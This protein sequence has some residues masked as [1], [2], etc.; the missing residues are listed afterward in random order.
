MS[1][2]QAT[3]EIEYPESDRKPMGET[4]LHIDWIIRIRDMLKLRYRG[5]QVYVAN[6]LLVY[7]HEG[8]PKKFVVPD[9]FVVKDCDPEPRRTFKIWEVGRVPNVV[10]EITSDST[11]SEDSV[12]E[13]PLYARIGIQ[14]YFLYD[15][16]GE[17]LQPSLQGYRLNDENDY[18]RIEPDKHGSLA[19]EQLGVSM[20][21]EG[22][23][24][25][26]SDLV[27][28]ERLLT[29]SEAEQAAR[30]S[31]EAELERLREQLK[32]QGG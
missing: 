2:D 21:L 30:K 4:D 31:A 6:D 23:A 1:I 10:L 9:C 26:M 20:R 32:Q 16:S 28:G 24:L 3:T 22:S 18:T 29:E 11:Q 15:P 5:Q 17:Y 7:Y 12:F 19:S 8:N 14:E 13:P 27:T 25:V